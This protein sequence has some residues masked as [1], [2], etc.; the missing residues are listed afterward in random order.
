MWRWCLLG[1]SLAWDR[2]GCDRHAPQ[3][4]GVRATAHAADVGDA[5]GADSLIAAALQAVSGPDILSHSA[6]IW[7]VDDVLVNEM[8]DERW[9]RTRRENV[10]AMLFVSRVVARVLGEGARTVHISSTAGQRGEAFHSEFR[11]SRGAMISFVE[12]QAIEFAKHGVTVNCVALGCVDTEMCA[13]VFAGGGRERT[14]AMYSN[15]RVATPQDVAW[16]AVV[17]C[18]PRARH[19]IG[20]IKIVNGGSVLPG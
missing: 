1:L 4:E 14:A 10:D 18:A 13:E 19:L 8:T 16:A 12:L 2:S 11:V 17:L 9:H 3:C 20:E 6:G 5:A 15:W 7:P